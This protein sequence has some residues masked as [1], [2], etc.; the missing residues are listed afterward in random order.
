[1]ERLF[2]AI[3]A[4]LKGLEPNENA[5]EAV[6]F[7]A[8]GDCAGELLRARTEPV[9]FAGHRLIVAVEDE[10]WRRHLTELSPQ[11]LVKLNSSLGDGTVRLIDFRVDPK[12]NYG[13]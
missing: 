2:A 6:V 11:M 12:L 4:I 10:T 5:A 3:P 1:M 8:W 7:G 13:R 9:K